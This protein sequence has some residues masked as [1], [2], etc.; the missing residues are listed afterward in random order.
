MWLYT[1]AI[2]W[3]V[4]VA[5]SF[6]YC[7]GNI[8]GYVFRL[9][10][11]PIFLLSF[12]IWFVLYWYVLSTSAGV[13]FSWQGKRNRGLDSAFLSLSDYRIGPLIF[14]LDTKLFS[15]PSPSSSSNLHSETASVLHTITDCI[16]AELGSLIYRKKSLCINTWTWTHTHGH[17]QT[18]H[19]GENDSTRMNYVV[20]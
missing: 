12:D 4:W 13:T 8:A 18:H 17:V 9:Q 11:G 19:T 20:R 2:C 16:S 10:N 6:K 3:V 7:P 1:Q 15:A 5:L 14:Q